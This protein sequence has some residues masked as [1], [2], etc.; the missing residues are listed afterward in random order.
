MVET[1]R[2]TVDRVI[3]EL[4]D[5]TGIANHLGLTLTTVRTDVIR[6]PDFPAPV[7]QFGQSKVWWLGDIDQWNATK[8]RPVGRPTQS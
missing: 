8:R 7:A 4:V 6:R 2:A 3:A 1:R 5:I